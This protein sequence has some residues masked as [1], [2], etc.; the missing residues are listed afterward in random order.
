MS[1]FDLVLAVHSPDLAPEWLKRCGAGVCAV[2]YARPPTLEAAF[3]GANVVVLVSHPSIE[4]EPRV[5]MHRNVIDAAV[6]KGVRHIF[7]TSQAFGGNLES[8]SRAHVMQAHLATEAYLA[9]I[10][11]P[12]PPSSSTSPS[13]T[14]SSVNSKSSS[15]SETHGV[16]Y[17][18]MRQ[19]IYSESYPLYLGFFDPEHPAAEVALPDDGGRGVTW[20]AR[21]DLGEAMAKLV[22][23]YAYEAEC[24]PFINETVLLSGPE[25]LSLERVAEVVGRLLNKTIAIK[26]VSSIDDYIERYGEAARRDP[27]VGNHIRE[28]ATVYEAI[29]AAECEVVTPTLEDWLGRPPESFEETIKKTLLSSRQ[30]QER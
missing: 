4:I 5:E 30:T 3:E 29:R 27:R 1:A 12:F 13:S 19:G 16:T 24:F 10:A 28:W 15:S 6:K 21:D 2:D 14:T 22:H 17:T 11:S 9:S 26:R 20:A 23:C 18:I 7:Y 25:A 8:T